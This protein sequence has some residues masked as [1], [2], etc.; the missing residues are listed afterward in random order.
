MA[1]NDIK[2]VRENAGSTYDEIVINPVF[3]KHHGIEL[4]GVPTFDDT[5]HILTV[6]LSGG[7][8][9]Y[10]IEGV[11]KD[12]TVAPTC[13]LDSYVTLTANTLYYFY[14]DEAAVGTLKASGDFPNLKLNALVATVYWN[15]SVG[16]INYEAH[17][18]T[19]D[20]DW[21]LLQHQTEGAKYLSGLDITAPTTANDGALDL[22]TGSLADEDIRFT[23]GQ[24][25]TSRI[26]YKV[27]AS[28][29]TFVNSSLPYAGTTGQPQYLDTDTYTLTNVAASD[30]V[31]MW[32]YGTTD[33]LRP[34]QIVPTHAATDHGI[35]ANARAEVQPS[36]SGLGL[37]PEWKLLYRWIYKG[38]GQ[39]QESL[40]YRGT[41]STPSGGSAGTTAGAV[42][43]TPAGNIS[44]TNVQAALVELDTEKQEALTFGIAD[45]N[46]VRIDHASV[47]DNDYAKFTANGLEG[48]TYAEVRSDCEVPL[49]QEILT[50]KQL[51]A[52]AYA[53][54]ETKVSTT[55]YIIVS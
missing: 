1:L 45:T 32:V 13:D 30:F 29:Y 19:R 20:I 34:I 44:A 24:C 36:L 54:L 48:R 3:K 35:I 40:D 22:S 21:H 28:K 6:P 39:F 31:C 50:I 41:D 2:G 23:T 9:K 18:H 15:G 38:D 37:N 8:V 42:S 5:E 27:S 17:N 53:A 11:Q 7:H 14:F 33:T 25:T 26:W 4:C 10:W 51:T 47:A 16:A 46:A 43:F 52:A 55:L 49:S 12:L